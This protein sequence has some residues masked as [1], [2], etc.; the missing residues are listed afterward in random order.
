M[1]QL[2]QNT[3]SKH[4]KRSLEPNRYVWIYPE[5]N[6]TKIIGLVYRFKILNRTK[7]LKDTFFQTE[8]LGKEPNLY[9]FLRMFFNKKL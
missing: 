5:K 1:V 7:P 8:Q 2:S 4:S 6:W 3:E 9:I